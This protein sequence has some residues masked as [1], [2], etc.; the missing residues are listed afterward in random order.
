V[1]GNGK[2]ALRTLEAQPFDAVLMDVQM[3]EMDG[4]EATRALRREPRWRDLPVIAM[5]ANAMAGDRERCL[6]AGM[7][8]YVSK[9]I[10]VDELFGVLRQWVKAPSGPAHA[11]IAAGSE[12]D[13]PRIAGREPLPKVVPGIDLDAGQARFLGNAEAYVRQLQTFASGRATDAAQIK[14][15]LDRGDLQ[16]AQRLAHTLKGVAGN[17]SVS[18]VFEAARDLDAALKTGADSAASE[19]LAQLQRDLAQAVESIQGAF[20]VEVARRDDTTSLQPPLL[21]PEVARSLA[22]RLRD[23]AEIGDFAAVAALVEELPE[24]TQWAAEIRRLSEEFD[25]EGLLRIA[26]DLN[27]RGAS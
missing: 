5:T 15:A 8:D 3:P 22:V 25:S 21:A 12:Y 26:D 1:A 20:P 16:A 13:G 27:E 23:A 17:L 6:D 24:G 2:E 9:P 18:A 11:D 10:D 19:A 14:D 7:N 4:L